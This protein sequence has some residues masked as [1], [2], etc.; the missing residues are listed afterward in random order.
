MPLSM[1]LLAFGIGAILA[2]FHMCGIMLVLRL[3]KSSF[4]HAH[5]EC[6]SKK[7]YVF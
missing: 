1:S 6:E 7:A 3:N 5:E 4:Q 2:N